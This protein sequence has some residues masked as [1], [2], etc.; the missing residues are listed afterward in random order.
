MVEIRVTGA[1]DYGQHMKVLVGGPA[2]AGKTLLSSTFPNA[3]FASAE[4]GLMSVARK[5][6]RYAV[7]NHT[8]ELLDLKNKLSQDPGVRATMLGGPVDTLVV[9]TIDEI[10]RLFVQERKQAKHSDKF[11][12]QD[13]GWLGDQMRVVLRGLRNL[14]M[15][16]VFTVHTKEVQ[17][18]DS[19]KIYIRPALQGAVGDEIA[20]YMDLALM[21]KTENN[22]VLDGKEVKQVTNRFLQT[23]PDERHD[24]IKD[25]SGQL[26]SNFPVNF[27]DDYDRL[28]TAIFGWIT[29]EWE[30]TRSQATVELTEV[31]DVLKPDEQRLEEAAVAR[32][33]PAEI[34]E[35][36]VLKSEAPPADVVP[37]GGYKCEEC[38]VKFDSQDQFD[39]SMLMTQRGL[40][41]DC[42]KTETGKG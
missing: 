20:Q 18:S 1:D 14:D 31:A 42:F 30:A 34:V 37:P 5:R 29:E 38:D 24:W 13:W 2:G 11:D 25:R 35:P 3:I 15:N 41:V 28:H 39:L 17:D 10:Q 36:D 16:V 32:D 22:R 21:L 4:S 27:T 23:F 9:D 40:C 7:I 6:L 12:M 33:V 19:G 8:D 26:P